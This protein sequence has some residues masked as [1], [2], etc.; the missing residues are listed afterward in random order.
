M[1]LLH[2]TITFVSNKE[3]GTTFTLKIPVLIDSTKA[4]SK[5]EL[6]FKSS[7]LSPELT[8][9]K[10]LQNLM[11]EFPIVNNTLLNSKSPQ[12]AGLDL[13]DSEDELFKLDAYP[14][15]DEE[16]G[17]AGLG[18]LE[19][20]T[21]LLQ[22]MISETLPEDLKAMDY[23]Y[24]HKNWAQV[25]HLAHKIKSDALYCGTTR[26]KFACQYLE[27]SHIAGH[28]HLLDALYKQF[29]TTVTQTILGILEWLAKRPK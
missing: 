16:N 22:L 24:A 8:S 21:E 17:I 1:E 7:L 13:P 9:L 2:G 20:L 14:L 12:N 15:L 28:F 27:R 26:L 18:D 29:S 11:H 5:P 23:A 3:E 25:E 19:T 10:I 6:S 4:Q